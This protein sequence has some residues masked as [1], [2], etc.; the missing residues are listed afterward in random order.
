M[1]HSE[2]IMNGRGKANLIVLLWMFLATAAGP[3]WAQQVNRDME[4]FAFGR[5]LA[6][7]LVNGCVIFTGTI[8]AVGAPEKEAGV[9]DDKRAIFTRTVALKIEERIYGE[10][11]GRDDIRLVYASRPVFTKTSLGPWTPWESLDPS[12]LQVG[13]RL[14]VIRWTEQASRPTWLGKPQEIALVV[15]D[16]D[17]FA[18]IRDIAEMNRRLNQ[19]S[20]EVQKALRTLRDKNDLVL[21]GYLVTYLEDGESLRDVNQAA[22]HLCSLLAGN[23]LPGQ[24]WKDTTGWFV[25]NFYRL[26]N[27][28]RRSVTENLV[29]A[30]SSENKTIAESGIAA[31]IRLGDEKL[32]EMSPFL[33]PDRRRKIVER[34]R[35]VLSGGKTA[36]Q[37]TEFSSQLGIETQ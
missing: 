10:L 32:L 5:N 8:Q 19:S 23:D 34:Y 36:K 20:E 13:R 31:L 14:L 15:A 16:R 24:A 35:E 18:V 25:S 28:T 4:K 33:T 37:H 27:E 21:A 30:A 3:V 29:A 12:D 6:V 1:N 7:Y 11:P 17:S 9:T 22:I 2:G 26:S